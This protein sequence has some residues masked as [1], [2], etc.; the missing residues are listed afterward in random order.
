MRVLFLGGT[1]NISSECARHLFERGHEIAVLT[2]GLSE[3]PMGYHAVLGE[4]RSPESMRAAL[5]AARPDVVVNFI[6]YDVSDVAL[7]HSIFA[8][9]VR[10]Y[11]FISSTTVHARPARLP[12]TEDAPVG[13]RFWDYARKK[14]EC[15]AWLIEK[16]RSEAF[17]ATIV[18]PS[19]TYSKRWIPNAV[20]SSN[21]AFADRILRGKPVFA[22]D[23]GETPWTLTAA[24]D[25]AVGLAGLIGNPGAVGETFHIT[26]EEVLTWN[27]IYALIAQ[28][29]GVDAPVIERIPTDFICEV[30]PTL[31]GTLK[32]DKAHPGI[33]DNAKIKRFAPEFECRKP[34]AEGIRESVEWLRAVPSR[35]RPDLA[36][37]AVIESVIQA[38]NK[39]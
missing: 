27:R 20:A 24:S 3:T 16:W 10:Q 4:R 14:A 26:S 8:G 32:G 33:F 35:W 11:V 15:E 9:K 23:D 2:R 7:D 30:A 22:H 19:H 36:T 13:N 5:E 29:L 25:F 28:S 17:P 34:F 37:D 31:T 18:R 6:G 21:Q 38:W 39:R 1:G 12:I